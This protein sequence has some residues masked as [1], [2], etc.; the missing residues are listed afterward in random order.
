VPQHFRRGYIESWNLVVQRTLP[1][2]FVGTVAYVGD[3]DVRQ[4]VNVNYLNAGD[5]PTSSSVCM[6]NQTFSP[7][8]GYTGACSFNAN[9][10]INIGAPCPPTAT[11]TAQGTCYNTGGITFDMPLWSAGYNGL[12][13]QLTRNAGKNSSLGVVY[14]YSHAIDYEDNGAGSGSQGTV[15]NYPAMFKLNRGTA[16]YDQK[17]NAQVYGIYSLPF[18]YGQKYANQ[19]LLGQIIG[20]FQLNGQFSHYS[21]TPFS[22]SANSNL[23]G[24]VAPGF[25]ATY[26][27][28]V[29]PYQQESGHNRVPGS[30]AAGGKPWFNP[31]SFANPTEPTASVSGNPGNVGPTLPN[32]GRNDFRGPGVSVFN[33]SVFRAI[34]IYHETEFQIRI[35][36]FNLL[37]HAILT[38]NPNTTVGGG[39][40]GYI[41]SF[42]PGYSPTQGSRSLQFSGRFN[43]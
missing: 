1:A 37:N 30:S 5:F 16:G 23:I 19:G 12:Q 28:L 32:T 17:H 6:P 7:T 14:T 8:S 22:V 41:T 38:S 24:N 29:A 9:E 36:A 18:G 20:G 42:G 3:H 26:A 25:G 10:T 4:Q 33:G 11:G 35:E 43:F 40:F 2:G 21:G 39:T 15:F 27:Q 31:A 13:T 34:H